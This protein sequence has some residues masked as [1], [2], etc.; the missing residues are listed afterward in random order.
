MTTQ[1]SCFAGYLPRVRPASAPCSAPPDVRDATFPPE[2]PCRSPLRPRLSRRRQ[3][4]NHLGEAARQRPFVAGS[5][6]RSMVNANPRQEGGTTWLLVRFSCSCSDSS[7][8]LPRRGHRGAGEAPEANRARDRLTCRLQGRRGRDRG[9]H[10]S[11]LSKT[12]RSRSAARW[13][14]C[15]L[16]DRPLRCAELRARCGRGIECPRTSS[17]GRPRD[18]RPSG[19]R[20]HSSCR[21]ARDLRLCV[22]EVTTRPHPLP[23]R[24]R[25]GAGPVSRRLRSAGHRPG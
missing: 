17:P 16:G 10:L 1:T 4:G 23:P 14:R 18:T 12:R 3:S 9:M 20:E 22:S 11:N 7:L 8:R 25:H 24:G 5:G 19:T 21:S 15:G 13:P 2:H 6:V